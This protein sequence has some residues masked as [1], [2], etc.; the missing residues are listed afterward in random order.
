MKIVAK[1]GNSLIISGETGCRTSSS[2]AGSCINFGKSDAGCRRV[3]DAEG[4]DGSISRYFLWESG[5]ER[6][7]VKELQERDEDREQVGLGVEVLLLCC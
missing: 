7:A 3:D 4:R 6:G 1:E 5:V 2:K